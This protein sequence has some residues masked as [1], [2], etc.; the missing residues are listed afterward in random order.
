MGSKSYNNIFLVYGVNEAKQS[1]GI[2][3]YE[4]HN[5]VFHAKSVNVK[6]I[7]GEYCG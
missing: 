2:L 4:S 3:G 5:N 7:A 6:F 1:G